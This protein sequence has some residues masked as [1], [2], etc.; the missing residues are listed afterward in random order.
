MSV[1]EQI[2]PLLFKL[3]IYFKA[4]F[5]FLKLNIRGGYRIFTS[6]T[7]PTNADYAHRPNDPL[8]TPQLANDNSLT[9]LQDRQRAP[10]KQSRR[11]LENRTRA[12]SFTSETSD[13][14][15]IT[16]HLPSMPIHLPFQIERYRTFTK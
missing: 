8:P 2:S 6:T 5:G 1:Q 15:L 10:L 12:D 14:K 13:E 3:K 11:C 16:G 7:E 9:G 4:H